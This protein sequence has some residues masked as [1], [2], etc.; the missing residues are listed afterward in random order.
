MRINILGSFEVIDGERRVEL[1]GYK[2]RAALAV[3]ALSP[4]RV[5]TTDRMIDELW[6]ESPPRQAAGSVQAYISNL[7]RALEPDRAPREPSQLLRSQAGGYL[8]SLDLADIDAAAFEHQASEG[9]NQ[10]RQGAAQAARETLSQALELWR[11]PALVEF[12]DEPF[13]SSEAGRLEELR[14]A[15]VEDRIEADLL[16]G[17]HAAVVAEVQGLLARAPLRER[18]W[19]HLIIALY[20]SGRQSDALAAYQQCRRALDE[21]GIEPSPALRKLESDVLRQ[22]PELDWRGPHEA[23]RRTG[24][25]LVFHDGSGRRHVYPLDEHGARIVIGRESTADIWL[26]WDAK[27][28]RHHAELELVGDQWVLVDDGMSSNGSFVA[29]ERVRGRRFLDDGDELRF[30]DTPMT[31]HFPGQAPAPETYLGE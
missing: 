23:K 10:L 9:R 15:A 27:V 6:G 28:S 18:L 2:Q 16:L 8:L 3:L 11:G 4:N 24:A 12:A 30:A 14:A 7:R 29:G 22:S 20:R 5:V 17:N 19:A 25:S 26:S 21:L 1:G 31:F 13:A